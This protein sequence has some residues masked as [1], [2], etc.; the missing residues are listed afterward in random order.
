MRKITQNAVNAFLSGKNFCE[1]NT[2]V[3]CSAFTVTMFLH[4]NDIATR[5]I[6]TGVIYIRNA[7]W[8]TN[9]TKERLN[10]IPG[11]SIV[12]KKGAWFLNGK[13]W[14]GEWVKV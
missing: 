10:G 6:N 5:E 2:G 12:Q 11:V 13:P 4:G 8:P 1:G 9:T 3:Q 7:D 14:S